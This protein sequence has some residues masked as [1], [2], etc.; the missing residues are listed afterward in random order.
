MSPDEALR[1]EWLQSSPQDTKRSPS[2]VS[3]PRRQTS[4]PPT[5]ELEIPSEV[6]HSLYRIYKGKKCM[7][8]ER[9]T[10]HHSGDGDICDNSSTR[11]KTGSNSSDRATAN[12]TH[13]AIA[14]LDAGEI[15]PGIDPSLDDSG[16]FLPPIL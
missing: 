4:I 13:S 16:T 10:S 1:H 2:E 3:C 12:S 5:T 15:P 8:K 6:G 11:Y 9:L 14:R 7:S